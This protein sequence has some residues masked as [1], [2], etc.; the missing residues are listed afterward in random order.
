GQKP[1][2]HRAAHEDAEHDQRRRDRSFDEQLGH[3][4]EAT[5][6]APADLMLTR[7]PGTSR[8]CP[9][10]TTVSPG[11]SPSLITDSVPFERATVTGR[12]STVLSALPTKTNG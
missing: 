4:H 9:S 2:R 7:R 5:L 11:C 12:R 1:G 3:V 8:S 6:P 10:V